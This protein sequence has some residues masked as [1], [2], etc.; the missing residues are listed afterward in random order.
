MTFKY[1]HLISRILYIYIY[2][3]LLLELR[4]TAPRGSIKTHSP[5]LTANTNVKSKK[6]WGWTTSDIKKIKNLMKTFWS[7]TFFS[8]LQLLNKKRALNKIEVKWL[9]NHRWQ[10]M[11]KIQNHLKEQKVVL[12]KRW[13]KTKSTKWKISKKQATKKTIDKVREMKPKKLKTK[14]L[15]LLKRIAQLNRQ[16]GKH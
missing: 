3:K 7:E 8:Y 4:C 15:N 10:L 9:R 12:I 5:N 14:K 2:I 1:D 6:M 16:C 11:N 13:Q